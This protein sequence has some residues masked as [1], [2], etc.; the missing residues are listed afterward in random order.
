MTTHDDSVVVH[1]RLLGVA[2]TIYVT[3]I[4]DVTTGQATVTDLLPTMD[5]EVAG[6]SGTPSASPVVV[7][8]APVPLEFVPATDTVYWIP[9]TR[10]V[11]VHDVIAVAVEVHVAPP[12]VAIAVYVIPIPSPSA[13]PHDTPSALLCVVATSPVTTPGRPDGVAEVRTMRDV[14]NELV[15]LTEIE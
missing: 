2:V 7:V 5:I 1:E 11:M 12:G 14:P 13:C 10:P 6:T 3:P 9:L 4:D 8:A 15:P